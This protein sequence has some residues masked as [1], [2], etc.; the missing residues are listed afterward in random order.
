LAAQ[1]TPGPAIRLDGAGD[2]A[3]PFIGVAM[4]ITALLADD[5]AMIR[6]GLRLILEDQPDISVVAEGAD[7]VEAVSLA[8]GGFNRW[9]RVCMSPWPGSWPDSGSGTSGE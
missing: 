5:Q 8:T 9:R 1:F 2:G 7:G 3:I 4:T 6:R